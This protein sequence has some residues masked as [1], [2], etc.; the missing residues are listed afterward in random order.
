MICRSA[1]PKSS[2]PETNPYLPP[3]S[4]PVTPEVPADK[5]TGK[6]PDLRI[7]DP[8]SWGWAAIT[9]I[10]ICCLAITLQWFAPPHPVWLAFLTLSIGISVT[11]SIVSYLVWI[12]RVVVN[13]KIIHPGSGISPGWAI[14]SYFIPFVNWIVP[15]M[16]MKEIADATF[17]GRA[18]R[19]TGYIVTVWWSSFMLPGLLQ[20]FLPASPLFT[21]MVWIAGISLAW[22]IIR[23]TLKQL[24]WREGG[25]PAQ[26]Q[27]MMAPG[28]GPRPVAATR[29]PQPA[30]SDLPA[31]RPRPVN[32]PAPVEAFRVVPEPEQE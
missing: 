14:G 28:G 21:S 12:H 2:D 13:A 5:T 8:R 23:I 4:D 19:T 17:R 22:L 7:K 9:F 26:P 25:L 16:T 18:P 32:R 31:G 24:D 11:A 15:A 3:A 27:P 29:L 10:W 20:K 1:P 6:K 30:G